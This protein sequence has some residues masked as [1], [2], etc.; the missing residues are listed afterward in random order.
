[1]ANP[2]RQD[3]EKLIRENDECPISENIRIDQF[4][5]KLYLQHIKKKIHYTFLG[6]IYFLFN[7]LI[8]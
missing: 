8:I 2:T 5:Q 7:D 1:M 3:V 6:I 4:L